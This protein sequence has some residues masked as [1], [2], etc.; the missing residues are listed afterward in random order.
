MMKYTYKTHRKIYNM[1]I[2]IKQR[3]YNPKLWVRNPCYVGCTMHDDW[4]YDFSQFAHDVE[5]MVGSGLP[6]RD[7][8]KDILYKGNKIYSKDTCILVPREI[9]LLLTY[10]Q[11]NN[12]SMPVGVSYYPNNHKQYRAYMSRYGRN[13]NLGHYDTPEEAYQA[14]KNGKEEYIKEV[15]NKYHNELDPR[16]YLALMNWVV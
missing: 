4:L 11:S 8:D 16:A 12:G 3:C 9:N 13:I 15:A 14:Y 10:N 1:W 5:K 6:K 7:I 2:N